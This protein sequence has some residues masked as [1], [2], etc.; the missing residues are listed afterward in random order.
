MNLFRLFA[1]RGNDDKIRLTKS[2]TGDWMVKKGFSILY[3]GSRE[4][5]ETFMKQTLSV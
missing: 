4:K 3:I 1:K 5:C 2:Q